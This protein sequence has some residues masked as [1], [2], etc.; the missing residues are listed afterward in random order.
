M[1]QTANTLLQKIFVKIYIYY[2][3][4]IY[5]S[6]CLVN[7]NTIYFETDSVTLMQLL[8]EENGGQSSQ[9]RRHIRH[10]IHH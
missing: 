5:S 8:I 1:E 2:L 7:L 4:S 9:R 3:D 6:Q 10:K